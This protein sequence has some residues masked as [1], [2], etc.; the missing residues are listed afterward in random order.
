M[1]NDSPLAVLSGKNKT[2]YHYFKQLFAQVTNPPIDPDPGGAGHVARL[3]HRTE[4]QPARRRRDEPAAA[5]RSLTARCSISS[6]WKRSATSSAIRTASS[7]RSS[8]TSL[9]RWH[10]ARRPSRPGSRALRAQAEDAVRAGYSHPHPFGPQLRPRP[11]LRSRRCSALVGHSSPSRAKG[12]RTSTGSRRG[13][14]L[15]A[16]SASLR[17][18]R[19]LRRRSRASIPRAARRSTRLGRT[20]WQRMSTARKRARASSRPSGRV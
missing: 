15:G 7:G 5:A 11:R 3:V 19:R 14:R 8:S 18:A 4:T 1:G 16:G 6:R 13:N 2:L 12:L 10:G 20:T 9:I 17:A